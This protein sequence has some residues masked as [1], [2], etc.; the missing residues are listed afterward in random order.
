MTMKHLRGQ[1]AAQ[2]ERATLAALREAGLHAQDYGQGMLTDAARELLRGAPT[3]ERWKQD[4]LVKT[5][6]GR[7]VLVDAKFSFDR[8]PNHS[9]EMR[10]LLVA[11]QT[12]LPTFYVCSHWQVG[13]T[14][15]PFEVLHYQE[16]A[17]VGPTSWPCC[18]R[19]Q[20]HAHVA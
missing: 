6:L 20:P 15:T 7:V 5:P 12:D 17:V 16:I 9:V 3:A 14:F 1:V 8:S 11:G 10:S 13:G 18:E 2:C 19:C 4:Y